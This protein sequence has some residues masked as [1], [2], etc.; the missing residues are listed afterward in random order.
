MTTWRLRLGILLAIGSVFVYVRWIE[1]NWLDVTKHR[2]NAKVDRPLK[3]L[4][5]SDVHTSGFGYRESKAISIIQR[6]APD[7]I[8]I[9][10]DMA[11]DEGGWIGVSEFLKHLRAPLGVFLIRGNWEH[12]NASPDEQ[13]IYRDAGVVFL[14]ND[15]HQIS[16]NAWLVGVDDPFV[17]SPD[18]RLALA[19]VPEDAFKIALVHS[20]AYF[21]SIRNRV[22]LVLAGH[23]HGGQMRLPFLRPFFLPDGSG[24]YIA[25]WYPG[26]KSRMYVSRGIGNSILE[27]RFGC[28]PEI[29]VF[30][31]QPI[32]VR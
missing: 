27:L 31:L 30:T 29:A 26:G 13:Q 1:P 15:S 17:G 10:G 7:A 24:E 8:V 23:T 21:D 4:Q 5:L 19:K 9:T 25:G 16:K 12:W 14:N 2:L 6:E 11:P 32:P 20:P 28:R 22:D 18:L 3:I